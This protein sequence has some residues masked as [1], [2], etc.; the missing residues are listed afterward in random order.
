[1]SVRI[2]P[3]TPIH[4]AQFIPYHRMFSFQFKLDPSNLWIK[5][6]AWLIYG[7]YW[8]NALRTPTFTGVLTVQ[9]TLAGR[10]E[11]RQ[12]VV[13]LEVKCQL[14]PLCKAVG[15]W[16]TLTQACE[17]ERQ[18]WRRGACN[19]SGLALY[20]FPHIKICSI[21]IIVFFF[22]L[23]KKCYHYV[24]T[25]YLGKIWAY[26]IWW[27]TMLFIYFFPHDCAHVTSVTDVEQK[28]YLAARVLGP[29]W[30]CLLSV[31]F[32]LLLL[33]F[34]SIFQKAHLLP[35]SG[36]WFPE[37]ALLQPDALQEL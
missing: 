21:R 9:S 37:M 3:F 35:W 5:F 17:L 22:L 32:V 13:E 1:M 14:A 6:A 28:L 7:A 15:W 2:V 16:P 30:H 26:W 19:L 34:F 10:S 8:D 31:V 29:Q 36:S 20:V 11:C 4:L 18:H 27:A 23:R 24:P 33:L 12:C 25:T